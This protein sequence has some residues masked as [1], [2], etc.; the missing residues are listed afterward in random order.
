MSAKP[1]ETVKVVV[2]IRPMSSEEQRNGNLVAAEAYS[3]RGLISIK[4][5]KSGESEPSKDFFFD[6][7]FGPNAEQ[8]NIYDICASGVV[9][10]VLNGYNGTIFAYGQTHTMEGR[11]DP[12]Y[13]RGI[14]PN[15]FQ[16]IFEYVSSAQDRQFLVRASY[17]EIYN[18]DIRDLLSKDPKNSLD[19][20]ENIDTGV[21]VKGLT[22]LVVKNVA[23]IDHVMQAGKKNRSVGETL[24]NKTS[25]RSHSIFTI[26]VECAEN[27]GEHIRVGKLNLVDLAGSERQSKT[28]AT[29]DRL[30]EANNINL[31]LA[32]L[33]NVITALVDGK[34]TYIPYR[35]SK[36]TRLLQNSLG[37]NAKT[38][39]C[40]NCGPADYNYDETLS[41]LR[42]A[43]R[44]KNIKNK[45]KINEDPKDAMLREYQ[46]QIR[47]LK[48][49][50]EATKRGVMIDEHGQAVPIHNARQEIVEKIVEREVVKEVKV[51]ISEEEMEEIR[52]KAVEEKQFLMKQ[53]AEDMKALID[54]QSRTA[55]ERAELQAALD[56]EAEDRR[57]LESQQKA[58][59]DKLR[60]MEEKLIKGGE[61][62]T[63]ASK[64]EALLRKAEQ[65]LR[66]R[67]IQEA[68]LARE[69][70]EKE[71]ANL[72]LEEHFSSLQEEVE[73]KTKKLKK[74]WNKYQGALKESQDLQQEFQ[75]ERTDMLDSIRQLT[76]TIKLKDLIIS[77]FIPEE[78]SKAIEKRA[79]YV[80][81]EDV[82]VV[83]RVELAGNN[84]KAS[85]SRPMATK[86]RR[87]E[88]DF[89]KQRKQFDANPRYKVDNILNLELDGPERTTQEFAGPGMVSKVDPVLD[90]DFN[91]GGDGDD[92]AFDG[93]VAQ[94]ISSP[95][96]SYGGLAGEG[97]DD[98][99]IRNTSEKS[100][101]RPKTGKKRS[102]EAKAAAPSNGGGADYYGGG[103][104]GGSNGNGNGSA[105]ARPKS[106]SRRREPEG[107]GSSRGDDYG[108]GGYQQEDM[109]YPTSRGLV[110]K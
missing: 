34:S 19:I 62:L 61:V 30:K 74:L 110:R 20:K 90:M 96:L 47:A 109:V 35:D 3:D 21:Y 13:L 1:D 6:A 26:V 36:L 5:P 80:E 99:S 49:Q 75:S 51:G 56:R 76:R 38:V 81:E 32:A 63:K 88:T 104:G 85:V 10:S 17:L 78:L 22:S 64:Q 31:S 18:E 24:M 25:S 8:K 97:G 15:S 102:S 83:P 93:S 95:Y 12:P 87:P 48:E 23:E 7:V 106:A 94:P 70:A 9:E 101:S 50:L 73:V 57:L 100:V 105:M 42:Y 40:A 41:T 67:Q 91:G 44:A 72:Q 79:Q 84:V 103:S 89:S 71:E 55:Q 2:R 82:W 60:G 46:D 58:L 11:P 68:E 69:L 98:R 66:Q 54:Q 16:H 65:E 39:M 4:N 108:G 43:N 14:I 92:V 86:G 27:N 53:A 107:N 33:G 37:G 45:P 59:Q 28:G 29:G 77:N 52:R